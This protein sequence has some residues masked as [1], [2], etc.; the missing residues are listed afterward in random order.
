[1]SRVTPLKIPSMTPGWDLDAWRFV[2]AEDSREPCPVII[3]A[4][5]LS[6][7]KL[8]SLRQYADAFTR[9]GYAC[10]VFDYRRWGASD[11]TPK[12]VLIV[13]E[14]LDDY[15][16]VIT[17]ARQQAEFD[18]QR[19][20]V[21]GTSLSGGHAIT[22]AA[23]TAVN[24]TAV[25]AQCPYT[26]ATPLLLNLGFLQTALYALLDVIKQ[27]I[28]FQ[29]TYIPAVAPRGKIGMLTTVGCE[30]GLL[31]ICQD[32]NDH[33]NQIAA[34]A[35]L[36]IAKY[37]PLA[38]ARSIACPVLLVAPEADNLC[39]M[40]GAVNVTKAAPKGHLSRIS[41]SGHF[42][43]YPGRKDYDASLEAQLEFLKRY[44]PMV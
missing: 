36:Q 39:L 5:G 2:P 19:V 8:M 24:P 35:L 43:V 34:S 26:G 31:G 20:I 7:N 27:A 3:M 11:G 40:E 29:P 14:Q 25:I 42:D 30:E 17:Y 28:G 23:E 38:T 13:E 18:P 32:K 33:P 1:M 44:V 15:R 12:N 41:H 6:A 22:L 21:W 37:H 4:H 16:T 10:L 9:I